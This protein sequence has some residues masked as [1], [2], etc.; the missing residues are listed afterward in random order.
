MS[1]ESNKAVVRRYLME[2][3]TNEELALSS[4]TKDAMYY[5]PGAP[6]SVGMKGKSD[7][8]PRS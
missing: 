2:G 7:A 6:P 1:V 5:D 3:P 4:L 8:L